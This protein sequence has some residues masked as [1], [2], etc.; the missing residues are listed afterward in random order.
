MRGCKAVSLCL[1]FFP[2]PFC[3]LNGIEGRLSVA[4]WDFFVFLFFSFLFSWGRLADFGVPPRAL[5]QGHRRTWYTG[6]AFMSHDASIIWNY[7]QAVV[8]PKLIAG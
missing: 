6:A 2:F 3:L 7:T 1:P 8:L 5:V 4:S